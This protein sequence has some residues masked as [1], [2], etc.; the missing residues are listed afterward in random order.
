MNP[1]GKEFITVD[2]N[3]T[4]RGV[5]LMS[6]D[7][8]FLITAHDLKF[9]WHVMDTG[10]H[11][12]PLV[13]MHG[14]STSMSLWNEAIEHFQ[15]E[16]RIVAVDFPGHGLSFKV[17]EL[18]ELTENEKDILAADLY[19]PLALTKQLE[20]VFTKKGL[21]GV[22]VLGWGMGAHLAFALSACAPDTISKIVAVDAPPVRLTP[23]GLAEGF[24]AWF[25]QELV[26]EWISRPANLSR[27]VAVDIARHLGAENDEGVIADL[28][29]TDPLLRKHLFA[30]REK[31]ENEFYD[32]LDAK[33]WAM[34][35]QVALLL[36]TANN[37][38]ING[39]YLLEC[40][41][42]LRNVSA[43]IVEDGSHII[44]RRNQKEFYSR[45]SAF[46]KPQEKSAMQTLQILPELRK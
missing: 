15:A 42:K 6:A 28:M 21:R 46:F 38:V 14:N 30:N 36:M 25:A 5:N 45:V 29:Q 27:E 44:F 10:S 8:G 16:Y 43:A 33:K 37:K 19:N 18:G 4:H 31:H 26:G 9:S 35:T 34:S 32:E 24:T 17:G 1:R 11:L 2:T 20:Q 23:A 13:F 3:V 41:A 39:A 40:A 12:P 7:A 22:Y